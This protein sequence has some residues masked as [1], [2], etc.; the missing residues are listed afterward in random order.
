MFGGPCMLTMTCYYPRDVTCAYHI[1][2]FSPTY[3]H[4]YI[5]TYISDK[6]NDHT[7]HYLAQ[8]IHET[9]WLHHIMLDKLI[10]FW[11][12]LQAYHDSLSWFFSSL[13]SSIIAANEFFRR[14][15]QFPSRLILLRTNE[16]RLRLCNSYNAA[17]A[18]PSNTT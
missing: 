3:R 8:K 15:Q 9:Q 5:H 4:T 6:N 11:W 2:F 14:S 10:T 12:L 16:E 17:A 1:L 13:A 18:E 7:F